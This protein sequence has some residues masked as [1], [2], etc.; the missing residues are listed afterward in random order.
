M[1]D[2]CYIF[3]INEHLHRI[4]Q[5]L[6]KC[7][8]FSNILV[9]GTEGNFEITNPAFVTIQGGPYDIRSIMHHSSTT[10]SRNGNPH[11][12][13]IDS[14]I[15]ASTLVKGRVLKVWT[16]YCKHFTVE[17][18]VAVYI[19][20]ILKNVKNYVLRISRS[21]NNRVKQIQHKNYHYK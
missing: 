15:S 5:N 4:I 3:L 21:L 1:L 9:I 19:A 8:P 16:T 2:F 11:I 6:A 20:Y 18:S 7:Y 14:G 10:F 17:M 13:P 12:L